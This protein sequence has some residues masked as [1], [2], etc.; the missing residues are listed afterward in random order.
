MFRKSLFSACLFV[1]GGSVLGGSFV[2]ESKATAQESV[3]D[4]IYGRG[5]HRYFAHDY[6][7]A[8]QNLTLAIENGSKDPRAHY[9][10]GLS[11]AALGNFAEADMNWQT[12]ATL[13]VEGAYGDIIGKSLSR[14][15]GPARLQIER[16]RQ[17]ARLQALANKTAKDNL[18]FGN[19]GGAVLPLGPK[20]SV[21]PEVSDPSS[22]EPGFADP[23]PPTSTDDPFADDPMAGDGEATVD[24]TDSLSGALDAAR[25]DA[26]EPSG[27]TPAT[28]DAGSTPPAD[29]GGFPFGGGSDAPAS[30]D[31]F[32]GF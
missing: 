26:V 16:A 6:Q 18:R 8:M 7:A 11:A 19:G 17:T 29:D 28:P 14:V 2:G 32:G 13:E 27:A 20:P 25:P 12:G 21:L 4:E 5:V 15:Q 24:S 22:M 9:F 30:D 1:A 31:P 3:L 10:R 23:V